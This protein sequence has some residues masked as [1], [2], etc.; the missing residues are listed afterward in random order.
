M[1]IRL[2]GEG[3]FDVADDEID[4]LNVLDL[5]LQDAIDAGDDDAFRSALAEL[6]ERVRTIGS[7]VPADY[8]GSS[9]L[10][11]PA[12]EATVE[13]VRDLLGEEGLIPG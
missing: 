13:E 11:L 2:L 9:D 6:L 8:L 12:A 10:V 3:Q 4:A 5:K 1:I 7:A